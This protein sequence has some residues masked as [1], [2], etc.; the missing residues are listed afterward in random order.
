MTRVCRRMAVVLAVV[1]MWLAGPP[2][3]EAQ[4]IGVG[5]KGGFLHT[6]FDAG[7]A[8][9]SGNGWM[10]G[11]FFGGNRPGTVGVMGE[12]NVLAKTGEAGNIDTNIYYLQV[13]ALL[14]INIGSSNSGL[15]S[16]IGYGIIGPAV[17]LKV[18][19]DLAN[20]GDPLDLESVDVSLVGGI[21]FEIAR[22]II[23]GRGTWGLRNI[24]KQAHQMDT[25]TSTFAILVGLRFN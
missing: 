16:A 6:S 11:L 23:E 20:L 17:E 21:G 18:G 14:R 8:L 4:G 2:L 5:I 13:P 19:D 24:A 7:T 12:F 22:F 25:K 15:R 10:A 3:A 9:D 1:P